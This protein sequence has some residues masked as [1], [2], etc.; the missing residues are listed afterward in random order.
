[1]VGYIIE[2]NG[3]YGFDKLFRGLWAKIFARMVVIR[4][5]L[6]ILNIG[7]GMDCLGDIGLAASYPHLFL[8]FVS[9]DQSFI[10]DGRCALLFCFKLELLFIMDGKLIVIIALI[11]PSLVIG[12]IKSCY[13][14]LGAA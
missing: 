6:F 4:G 11:V 7:M 8:S 14:R 13:C 5:E 1:V 12:V 2:F 10:I 3:V 9:E